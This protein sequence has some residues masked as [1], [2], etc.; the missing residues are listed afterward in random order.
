[1]QRA[2]S[3]SGARSAYDRGCNSYD[4]YFNF[5]LSAEVVGKLKIP[6]PILFK[7]C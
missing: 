3:K 1:M 2:T 4:I 5:G 7:F 6:S